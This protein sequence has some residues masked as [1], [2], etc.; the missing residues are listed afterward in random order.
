MDLAV[1]K[2][3]AG[4]VLADATIPEL[5][6]PYHGKVRDNYDLPDGRRIIIA[7]DRFADAGDQFV[8]SLP[9][10]NTA[11]QDR[12]FRPEPVRVG[13]MHDDFYVHAMKIRLGVTDAS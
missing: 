4:Q 11:L 1:L 3:Q 6:S 5:P 12:N 2:A 7:S 10:G 9:L 8:H 13:L